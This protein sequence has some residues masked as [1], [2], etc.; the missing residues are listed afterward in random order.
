MGYLNRRLDF[1]L[2]VISKLED[3]SI[4]IIYTKGQREK[5]I[6]KNEESLGGYETMSVGLMYV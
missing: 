5:V 3:K 1:T 2:E 4:E 6:L